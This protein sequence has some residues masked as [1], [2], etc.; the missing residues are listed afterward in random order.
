MVC[1]QGENPEVTF[2]FIVKLPQPFLFILLI[3]YSHW[4]F[5]VLITLLYEQYIHVH[6]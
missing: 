3:L 2:R 4:P 1:K 6:P 5:N